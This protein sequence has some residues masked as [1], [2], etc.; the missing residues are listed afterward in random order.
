[1]STVLPPL[2]ATNQEL[3]LDDLNERFWAVVQDELEEK[4][5]SLS[6]DCEGLLRSFVAQG[7]KR[8]VEA[9]PTEQNQI[10]AAQRLRDLIGEMV[11]IAAAQQQMAASAGGGQPKLIIDQAVFNATLQKAKRKGWSFWPFA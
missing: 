6:G 3:S 5:A 10:L 8:F 11:Q 7:A 2:N 1:M 9:P 4:S